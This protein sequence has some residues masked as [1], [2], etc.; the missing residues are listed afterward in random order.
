MTTRLKVRRKKKS[1]ESIE[2][3]LQELGKMLDSHVRTWFTD[4]VNASC[5]KCNESKETM[6]RVASVFFCPTCF[7][8]EFDFKA[9]E[10]DNEKFKHWFTVYKQRYL[11]GYIEKEEVK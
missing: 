3:Q 11:P 7:L 2:D 4:F 1:K 8:T 10:R 9:K 5:I 6:I